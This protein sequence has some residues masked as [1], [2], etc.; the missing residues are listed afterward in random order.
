LGVVSLW[1]AGDQPPFSAAEEKVLTDLSA[2]IAEAFR[3]AALL[4]ALVARLFAEHYAEPLVE[5]MAPR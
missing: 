2:P 4:R 3:R 5:G 1:R